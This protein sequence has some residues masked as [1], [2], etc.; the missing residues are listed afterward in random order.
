M[1]STESH[2]KFDIGKLKVRDWKKMYYTNINQQ[3]TGM[4]ILNM[5]HF[6]M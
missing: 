5:N 1:L 2:L 3:K 6:I 4:V